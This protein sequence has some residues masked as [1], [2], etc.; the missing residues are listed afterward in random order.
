VHHWRELAASAARVR[1]QV[2]GVDEDAYPLDA[3]STMRYQ[4]AFAAL[5]PRHALPAPLDVAEIDRFLD[6]STDSYRLS[7][8]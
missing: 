1:G 7:W 5:P 3:G 6:T 2:I 4:P 8:R